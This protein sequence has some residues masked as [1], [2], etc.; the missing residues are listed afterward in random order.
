MSSIK[1]TAD[2]GGGTVELKAPATTDSNAAKQFI[3]P[4]NDGS[5]SQ[6]MKTDGSGNLAFASE[7]ADFVKLASVQD[8][9]GGTVSNFTFD[10]L[11]T[12][13]YQAFK[14]IMNMTPTDESS[15]ELRFRWRVSG[16]DQTSD[17]YN[18][19][20]LGVS[21][22]GSY[23]DNADE[24]TFGLFSFS[25]GDKTGEGYRM[26]DATIIPKTSSDF[27]QSRNS[28]YVMAQR[29]DSSASHRGETNFGTYNVSVNPDGFIIYAASG[30]FKNY[31]YTLYG[32]KR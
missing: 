16:T 26:I 31:G 7:T 5:A 19:T 9:T 21:G 25:A 28:Y 1:L 8:S 24:E 2:S 22:G 15:V 20:N 18:W 13:T 11:D 32:L 23:F 17:E 3:L 27:N 10:S 6:F 29:Y 14:L 12:S 30:S 4:Q